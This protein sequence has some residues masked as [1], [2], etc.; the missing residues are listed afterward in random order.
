MPPPPGFACPY[1]CIISC[2]YSAYIDLYS[3]FV[4][5]VNC[6]ALW[7]KISTQSMI[8]I[9]NASSTFVSKIGLRLKLLPW[10]FVLCELMF[11]RTL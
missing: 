5:L 11:L 9:G 3:F 2:I 1:V 4:M 10:L 7:K 6:C 8:V